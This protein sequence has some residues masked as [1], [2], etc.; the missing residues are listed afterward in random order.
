VSGRVQI[1]LLDD[2]A[3]FAGLK[4]CGLVWVCPVCSPK[5]RQGRAEEIGS[6]L[7]AALDTGYGVEF[8]TLTFRHHAGQLLAVLLEASQGAWRSTYKSRQLRVALAVLEFLGYV[9]VQE[10]T[11]G[12]NGWHPHRHLALVFGRP[13]T[14]EEREAL[15]SL[16]WRVWN[17]RLERRGLSSLRGPGALLVACER[18]EGLGRYLAKVE[19]ASDEG[20]TS[21]G[22]EMARG[23][24][25]VG[26]FGART[27]QQILANALDTGEAKD[28]RLWREYE[29]ATAGRKLMTWSDGLRRKLLGLVPDVTDEELAE[30]ERGGD[31]LATLDGDAWKV[32]R[33]ASPGGLAVLEAA[34]AGITDLALYLKRTIPPGHGRWWIGSPTLEDVA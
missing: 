30:E 32:V 26:R 23:D 31:V 29:D 8:L 24:L 6:A 2:V 17:G 34:E 25:K 20:S 28:V 22:L 4:T 14:V 15:E 27:P 10:V 7:R 11:H 16:V 1:R 9:Q 12:D 33:A 21:L 3:H 19:I 13:L 5:I 18:P